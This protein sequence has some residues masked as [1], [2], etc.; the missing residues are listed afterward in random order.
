MFRANGIALTPFSRPRPADSARAH[1]EIAQVDGYGIPLAEGKSILINNANAE[2]K[3]KNNGNIILFFIFSK[4]IINS[5]IYCS[6]K[7]NTKIVI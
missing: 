5:K 6:K 1:D 2:Q 4:N 3:P 7:V